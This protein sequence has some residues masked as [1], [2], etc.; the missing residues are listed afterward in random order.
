MYADDTTT[1]TISTAH[2]AAEDVQN[3]SINNRMHLNISKCKELLI[4]FG[5]ISNDLP[6]SISVEFN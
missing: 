5:R 1:V 2:I 6:K 4:Y 3:W